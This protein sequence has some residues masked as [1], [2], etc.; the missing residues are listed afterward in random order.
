MS[1]KN[2]I[3][4]KQRALVLQ[5]GGALGAYEAGALSVLCQYL[6]NQGKGKTNDD[7]EKGRPLF[8][9]V[10][11]TSMGAMN[12]A[13]LVSNVVNRRK[14]WIEAAKVLESFWTDQAKED[15]KSGGLSSFAAHFGDKWWQWWQ[16]EKD[17]NKL[18]GELEPA[19]RHYSVQEYLRYGA[20]NVFYPHVPEFDSK[21][22]DA[23]NSWFVYNN[24]P[25][26]Q[27]IKRYS[28]VDNQEKDGDLRIATSWDKG[29]PRLLVFSVD[30]AEGKTVAF[31]SYHKKIE[32][33]QNPLYDDGDGIT[34]N[35]IMASGTVPVFYKFRGIPKDGGRQFCDGGILSNTPF[36]E[37]LQAHRDYWTRVVGK[38]QAKIP[39][40]D[41]YI[42]NVHPSKQDTVPD[43]HDAIKDRI[44]DIIFSDR[45]SNYDEMVADL[46]TDHMELIA[47][48]KE[49]EK[50]HL[51]NQNERDPFANEFK[52]PTK[53]TEAKNDA[54]GQDKKYK[55][56]L[57]GRFRLNQA[58]RIEPE[59]GPESYKDSISGKG[60][61]FTSATIKELIKKGNER[62]KKVLG[63]Q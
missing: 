32:D 55:D 19:R 2:D 53:A 20:P 27:T 7:G 34:I 33:P 31:D 26:E 15:E 6:V 8:D 28:K 38:V 60:A 39:D 37:L 5:G 21:F 10:A 25:L 51:G 40:L 63:I 45:N 24:Y 3:P 56:L 1:A 12:A 4:Q 29:E 46:V 18:K 49:L 42:I 43:D 41:V 9:I 13:V 36:K 16:A 57:K 50:S 48:L 59:G 14:T 35:H 52:D 44:N 23:D 54:M 61:D 58:I 47:K 17:H 11:G 30:V 62:A 22:G